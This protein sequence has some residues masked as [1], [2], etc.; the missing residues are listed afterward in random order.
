MD[1]IVQ[2][3]KKAVTVYP[4]Q[5]IYPK[6][7][8]GEGLNRP[9]TI[10]LF[11]VFPKR[12]ENADKY[13]QMIGNTTKK[14][15][16]KL[17][18]FFNYV[19]YAPCLLISFSSPLI[20]AVVLRSCKR[21]VGIRSG[22]FQSLRTTGRRRRGGGRICATPSCSCCPYTCCP[23]RRRAHPPAPSWYPFPLFFRYWFR[24]IWR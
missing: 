15:G 23:R 7:P 18:S 2:F 8:E 11:K 12:A 14:F 10:T 5:G 17:V 3:E 22:P 13:S 20:I 24:F 6:A 19:S 21:S 9:A 16:A 1:D 4:E